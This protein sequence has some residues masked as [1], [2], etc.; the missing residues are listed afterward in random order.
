MNAWQAER[1]HAMQ[2]GMIQTP[3]SRE[4]TILAS[5]Q[6]AVQWK[7][8]LIW[9]STLCS[10]SVST[11]LY[12]PLG[13]QAYI[14][15]TTPSLSQRCRSCQARARA[16][17][18]RPAPCCRRRLPPARPPAMEVTDPSD[19]ESPALHHL[20]SAVRCA[21]CCD[22]YDTPLVLRGCGHSCEPTQLLLPL[23]GRPLPSALPLP[24]TCRRPVPASA[25]SG[26]L[27]MLTLSHYRTRSLLCLHPSESGVQGTRQRQAGLPNLPPPLRRSGPGSQCRSEGAQPGLQGSAAGYA[28]AGAR[29]E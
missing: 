3:T 22:V 10:R 4:T 14:R 25:L 13:Q 19:F 8:A 15:Y 28:G 17:R 16:I 20:D 7:G 21:I 2:N 18:P 24:R 6:F 1:W 23:Q 11:L 5:I 12:H 26:Q 9:P 27:V 29:H